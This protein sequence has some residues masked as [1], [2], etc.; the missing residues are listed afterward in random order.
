MIDGAKE[1][2]R[3]HQRNAKKLD[4]LSEELD[5]LDLTPL[6]EQ[7]REAPYWSF[8]S[9]QL[10]PKIGEIEQIFPLCRRVVAQ[11][12]VMAALAPLAVV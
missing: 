12:K 3:K 11:L 8:S 4:K 10:A 6:S 9:C 7:V 1:F 2:N 5:Q